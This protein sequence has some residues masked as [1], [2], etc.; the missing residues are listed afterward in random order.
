MI[1]LLSVESKRELRAARHNVTLRQYVFT[2]LILGGLITASYAVGYVMLMNQ[3]NASKQ[4]LAQF[5]PQREQYAK[6]IEEATTYNDNLT[7]AK[8]ILENEILF[9]NFM[10]TIAK[11]MPQGVTL[12][13]INLKAE[14]FAKQFE[15]SF[16]A[17]SYT[18]SL[19][20]KD[21]F[22]SSP[23]FEDVKIRT[24][25]K[26]PQGTYPFRTIMQVTFDQD[27][28]VKAQQEKSL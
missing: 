14:D 1:N 10:T 22:E 24:I 3:E 4:Q 18:D 27:E 21:L 25:I 23:Y 20:N 11:T 9:S 26:E 8:S 15:L 2:I 16:A 13:N 5:K 28:F 19:K 17:K 6:T 7:I 12:V